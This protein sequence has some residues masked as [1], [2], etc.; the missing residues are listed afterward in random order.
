MEQVKLQKWVSAMSVEE[1]YLTNPLCFIFNEEN[2]YKIRIL[3]Q[4]KISKLLFN[5]YI[6]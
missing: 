5:I 2:P 1:K 6:S 4:K 3:I